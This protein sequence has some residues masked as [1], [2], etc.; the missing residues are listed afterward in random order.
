MAVVRLGS[1]ALFVPLFILI[2][3]PL[4]AITYQGVVDRSIA[5][6]EASFV[7]WKNLV[8]LFADPSLQEVLYSTW[9]YA[10]P[11]VVLS[12][13]LGTFT[14]FILTR[15]N[16]P[17][18]RLFEI[19]LIFPI[20]IPDLISAIGWTII[21]GPA[22]IF[23][24][25]WRGT[26]GEPPWYLY[27]IP[28]MVLITSLQY[29]PYVYLFMESALRSI[30]AS[31]EFS[32][33]IT[34]AGPF[35][36]ALNITLPLMRP[37]IIFSTILVFVIVFGSFSI[38]LIIGQPHG[39]YVLTTYLVRL[40]SQIPPAYSKMA[41]VG[42]FLILQSIALITIQRRF[43]GRLPRYVSITGRGFRPHIYALGA[44]TRYLAVAAI[45]V[46]TC[47]ALIPVGGVLLRSFI[48]VWTPFVE[49]PKLFTLGN[50]L[51]LQRSFFLSSIRNTITVAS[52]AAGLTLLISALLSYSI[53]RTR[54]TFV[55]V[56]D[57]IASLP[58]AIPG[59]VLS[60]GFLWVWIK[61]PIGL[62][63]TLWILV[64]ALVARYLPVGLRSISPAV[65]QVSSELENSARLCGASWTRAFLTI[66]V[67][68]VKA[69]LL[70]S[71]I[72]VF[73]GATH[74]L[75]ATILLVSGGTQVMSVA[76]VNALDGGEEG[77]AAALSV[78]EL[79]LATIVATLGRVVLGVRLHNF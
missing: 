29:A 40:G 71:F 27:S 28:G 22:G 78:V 43:M 1:L 34:G 75:S 30:D 49:L 59:I 20:F 74:E 31:T 38:P 45:L 37:A 21:A 5:D 76:V 26:L 23:S 2:V 65:L 44:R 57:Y 36:T 67:P 58:V 69:G 9:I 15:T 17:L 46:Y 73:I 41:A 11:S 24:T 56:N 63:A 13:L 42:V 35:R 32:A 47:L 64:I 39:I 16:V 48:T 4:S 33:R 62:H 68:L 18:T 61:I 6:P 72:L 51:Q 50:F 10:G 3:L 54:D 14:A 79:L 53:Y 70:A 55:R 77:V 25:T 19:V 66:F 12:L 7:G 60:S 8:S 52:I